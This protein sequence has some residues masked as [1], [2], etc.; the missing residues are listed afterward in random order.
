MKLSMQCCEL[1][2]TF[3]EDRAFQIL[4]EA[5]FDGLDYY[6]DHRCDALR[7]DYMQIIRGTRNVLDYSG[8]LCLQGHA[9][10]D[11]PFEKVEENYYHVVHSIEMLGELGAPYV[12]VHPIMPPKEMD[13][14]ECNRK[15]Y[16]SLEK[17]AEKAG[18]VI[19]IENLYHRDAKRGG[20]TDAY[21]ANPYTLRDFVK[22][23]DSEW[24]A[25]CVDIGHAS[26]TPMEP[27]DFIRVFDNKL[28]KI[29]HVQDTDYLDD[30]HTLPGL[31]TLN[32]DNITKALAEI[33]YQG[34]LSFEINRYIT[35]LMSNGLDKEVLPDAVKLA[36]T[37]GRTLI[38]KI[39]AYRKKGEM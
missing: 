28:L 8:L 4:K 17:H 33:N 32:W 25:V 1:V 13:F 38:A 14:L 19:A 7:S 34:T 11:F 20:Y 16:K 29:L 35:G 18:V 27:E 24:F 3:G 9:P 23:L 21:F 36:A 12:V 10:F 22:S 2:P 15:Y 31:G 5:G 30:R 37:V 26:L 39:E 6:I